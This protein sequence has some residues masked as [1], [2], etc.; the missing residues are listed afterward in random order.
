MRNMYKKVLFAAACLALFGFGCSNKPQ[1]ISQALP[2][3]PTL[4]LK[5][6]GLNTTTT[7]DKIRFV[8]TTNMTQ[9]GINA[10]IH[11]VKFGAFD[12]FSDLHDGKNL[13]KISVGNGIVTST[14]DVNVERLPLNPIPTSTTPV[15]SDVK[16]TVGQK[17]I[18]TA[19]KTQPLPVPAKDS[20]PV[21]FSSSEM[22]LSAL[23]NDYGA[24]LDWGKASEPFQT[25]VVVKSKTD[26]NLYFP[27]IFWIQAFNNIDLRTWTDRDVT[28]GETYYRICKLKPDQSVV[29]GNVASVTK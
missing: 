15:V 20:L 1:V 8:G 18:K 21:S 11:N 17:I 29:C 5:E 3:M 10:Q 13:F 19:P 12:I 22:N 24:R 26:P 9:I 14:M 25:Y 28:A 2:P 27:K 16:P 7:Q 6:P 23:L 4:D